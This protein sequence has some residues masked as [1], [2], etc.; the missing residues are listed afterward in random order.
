MKQL[1][2]LLAAL[3]LLGTV[4]VYGASS[5]PD[6]K[7]TDWYASYVETALSLGIVSG[8]PDGSFQP[9]RKVTY[10]EFFAMALRG[11]TLSGSAVSS[12][13]NIQDAFASHWA[14][15]FYDTAVAQGI[16]EEHEIS[17]RFL[18]EAIPR[19]DMALVLGGVL[20]SSGLS[21]KNV[22]SADKLFSDVA[23]DDAREYAIAL[24]AYYGI[25]AGYPDGSFRPS[26]YLS[27]AE[28]AA[29]MTALDGVLKQAGLAAEEEAGEAGENLAV[30][31]SAQQASDE[32]S[33]REELLH[34]QEEHAL[35]RTGDPEVL[36]Y[37]DPAVRKYLE[38]VVQSARFVKES[39][40]YLVRLSWN[41]LP[42]GYGG[43]IDVQACDANGTGLDGCVW[44]CRKGL[45]AL[46]TFCEELRN[47][48]DAEYT[49]NLSNLQSVA[50]VGL[51]VTVTAEN[52]V[53]ESSL[54]FAEADLRSGTAQVQYKLASDS[55]QLSGTF[56]LDA[57]VFQWK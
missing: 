37:M 57:P 25:L 15:K 41:A 22:R 10:G 6:V 14:R 50:T 38:E 24:C 56:D 26:G 19:R 43:K 17:T 46:P 32:P 16:F 30:Q 3:L 54:A 7:E 18:D 31:P 35:I 47:A 29:A 42:Q 55:Y 8:Y 21:G 27:R 53:S 39:G 51:L 12:G 13:Q 28:S 44:V 52:G 33:D 4:P 9:S 49:F 20:R 2:S 40:R 36:N 11:K 5:F 45:E 23:A 48:G 34:R 1:L